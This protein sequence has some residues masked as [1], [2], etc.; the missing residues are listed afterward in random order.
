SRE[1]YFAD[2]S[3]Q[4]FREFPARISSAHFGTTVV[5]GPSRT[6]SNHPERLAC[7][8]S[9]TV[10]APK[11]AAAAE[12]PAAG[13]TSP[14][15]PMDT[16]TSASRRRPSISSMREGISPNQTMS[17]RSALAVQLGHGGKLAN[18]SL[19]AARSSHIVHHALR[20]S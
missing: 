20:S 13:Y 2:H 6:S 1:S 12:K 9:S 11:V 16:K 17:G 4:A 10:C 14:E 5:A 7:R 8:L 3:Y 18:A 19:H 15:V